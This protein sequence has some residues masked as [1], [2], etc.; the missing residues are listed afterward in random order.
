[1]LMSVTSRPLVM[2]PIKLQRTVVMPNISTDN[3]E[4][5]ARALSELE[6]E[7]IYK[8]PVGRSYRKTK[9]N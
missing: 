3:D 9:E 5:L 4:L 2:T 1:M 7:Y 8:K 6:N